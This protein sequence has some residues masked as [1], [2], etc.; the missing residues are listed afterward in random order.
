MTQN[1]ATVGSFRLPAASA[2]V[3]GQTLT[4]CLKMETA[5]S[6]RFTLTQAMKMTLYFADTE[7]ASIKI[8]GVKI[9]G[10]SSTY[11]TTLEA[12]AHEL[13]KDKSV[14]LFAIKLEPIK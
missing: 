14:N 4:T 2:S 1:R 10:T 7:V 3:D 9:Q 8:D 6:I 12:G 13:T 11:T 5:T